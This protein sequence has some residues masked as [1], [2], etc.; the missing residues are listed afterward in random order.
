MYK[1]NVISQFSAAHRLLGYQGDCKNLHGHNWKVRVGIEC[2][3]L[4]ELGLAID[5]GIIKKHLNKIMNKFDH[6]YLN[7]LEF[8]KEINPSSENIA[9]IIFMEMSNSLDKPGCKI[10]EVEIWESDKTSLI[11]RD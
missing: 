1:L 6:Q 4:D 7:D 9:R 8:F 3:Q 2:G 5:F 10:A 11:Y